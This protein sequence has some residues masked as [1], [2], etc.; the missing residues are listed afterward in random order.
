M[1][2]I[3]SYAKTG[4]NFFTRLTL[5]S[6]KP[7][8]DSSCREVVVKLVSVLYIPSALNLPVRVLDRGN[9]LAHEK[10]PKKKAFNERVR[11][12]LR[13]TFQ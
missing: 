5:D 7:T 4:P 13:H 1:A 12:V 9:E 8:N 10:P 2:V 6:G 3:R 11:Q